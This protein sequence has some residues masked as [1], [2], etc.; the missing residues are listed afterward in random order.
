MSVKQSSVKDAGS[1]AV[2]MRNVFFDYIS[3]VETTR[4]GMTRNV[5]RRCERESR[6][7]RKLTK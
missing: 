3:P 1:C 5:S 4:V 7:R 2:L 6:S